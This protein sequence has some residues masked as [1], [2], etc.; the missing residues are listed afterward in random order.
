MS[1]A[2]KIKG[3]TKWELVWI[4]TGQVI[5][6]GVISITGTAIGLTGRSVWLAY[7]V[8]VLIG[9]VRI[10]PQIFFS[11]LM[12]LKGGQY[13]IVTRTLGAKWGGIVTM[14]VFLGWSVRGVAVL[15]IGQYVHSVFPEISTLVAGFTLW[16]FIYVVNIFGINIM[17][18]VQEILTPL[19]L[20]ALMVFAVYGICN[21][22]PAALDFRHPEFF[23]DGL[24]GF[25]AAVV[26]LTYSTNGQAMIVALS[27][28]CANPKKDLPF[29]IFT[30]TGIIL[31]VYTAV[32]LAGGGA[33]PLADIAGKPLTPTA[34][35]LMPGIVFVFFMIGGPILALLTTMNSG[36]PNVTMPVVAGV[37]EG[38]LPM[39][40]AKESKRCI[41]YIAYTIIYVIGL[42]PL[43]TGIS[44]GQIVSFVIILSCFTNVLM[45]CSAFY[46]PIRFPELWKASHLHIPAPLY[47]FLVT[48]YAVFQVYIVYRS[49][50]GLTLNM[51]IVNILTF[52]AVFG[53]G[54]W[55]YWSGKISRPDDVPTD[56]T[57]VVAAPEEKSA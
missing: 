55:R 26:L 12:I 6:A 49:F 18:K 40:L 17:A 36:I 20:L 1:G 54:Y 48:L 3:L 27:E 32:A 19:L 15:A 42:I 23:S 45:I 53:Y 37:R 2:P 8:A 31:V 50:R 47:Y 51:A 33:L 39:V 11:S 28:R 21:L 24:S 22:T 14:S 38:W 46:M 16:T 7:A 30:A 35:A 29:A 41:P 52:T 5:G 10:L 13:G 4:A 57:P 9:L 56:P 34:Q 25:L 43:L 44:I